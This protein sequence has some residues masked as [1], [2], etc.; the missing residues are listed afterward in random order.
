MHRLSERM[1]LDNPE[2]GRD[3]RQHDWQETTDDIETRPNGGV[4]TPSPRPSR[5]FLAQLRIHLL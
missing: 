1:R 3:A 4:L 2:L 5:P